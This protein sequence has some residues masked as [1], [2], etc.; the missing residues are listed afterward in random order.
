MMQLLMFADDTVLHAE[1]E[2]D[3][4]HSVREFSKAEKWHRLAMNTETVRK[5]IYLG[6]ILCEDGRMN[7]ELEKRIGAA[8]RAAGAVRNQVFESRKLSRSAK[9]LVYKAMIEHTLTWRRILGT[10]REEETKNSGS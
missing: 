5:Q 9:M 1:M 4:Q 3:L 7:C 10:K 8:L 2:E 6:V